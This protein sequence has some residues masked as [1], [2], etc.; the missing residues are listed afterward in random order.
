MTPL[1]AEDSVAMSMMASALS[2]APTEPSLPSF[3]LSPLQAGSVPFVVM[4]FGDLADH[5]RRKEKEFAM[6]GG[7]KKS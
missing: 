2:P 1:L 5:L 3:R 6:E 7:L 4:P